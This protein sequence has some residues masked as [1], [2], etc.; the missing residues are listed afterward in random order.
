MTTDVLVQIRETPEISPLADWTG[1]P[2]DPGGQTGGTQIT[3]R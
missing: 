3:R 2:G 1:F